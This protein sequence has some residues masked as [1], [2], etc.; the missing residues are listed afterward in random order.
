MKITKKTCKIIIKSIDETI[1]RSLENESLEENLF[2]FGVPQIQAG[3]EPTLKREAS[4]QSFLRKLKQKKN[5]FNE[6]QNDKFYPSDSAPAHIYPNIKFMIDV[7]I[8]G[9]NNLNLSLQTYQTS[10][11]TGLLLNF[12]EFYI[13]FI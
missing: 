11:Y 1:G 2:I 4:L 8:S 12:K 7:F 5:F 3:A 13:I 9:I 10:T 6:N